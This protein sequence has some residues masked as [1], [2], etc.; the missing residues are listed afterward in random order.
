MSITTTSRVKSVLGIPAGITF[1]DTAL[2]YAVDF[3]NDRVLRAL[4]QSTLAVNTTQEYPVVYDA[5]QESVLLRHSP[6]V[7]IVALTNDDSLLD[8]DDYWLDREDLGAL[9]LKKGGG[10]WSTERQGVKVLYA[11]GY[12]SSTVPAEVTHAADVIAVSSFNRG[13]HAG[14]TEREASGYQYKLSDQDLPPDARAVLAR[15]ED[16]HRI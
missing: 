5:G 9:R 12:T 10:Y 13:K 2:G 14:F 7:Q 15:Y 16:V 6:V 1:H 8:D 3:A 11:W 4:G